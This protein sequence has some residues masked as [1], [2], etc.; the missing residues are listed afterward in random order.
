MMK[1]KRGVP[2]FGRSGLTVSLPGR[3]H[4]LQLPFLEEAEVSSAVKD[5]VVEQLDPDDGS[6]R[7]ELSS[8]G[9]VA[10]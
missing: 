6:R 2:R 9:D 10:R 7:L 4:G 5:D 8:Y 3:Y 1:C